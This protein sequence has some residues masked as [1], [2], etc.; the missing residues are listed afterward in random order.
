MMKTS[1]F[2]VLLALLPACA[3]AQAD[4]ESVHARNACRLAVQIVETGHPAPH[5]QW[6]FDYVVNCGRAGGDALANAIHRTRRVTDTVELAAVTRSLRTFRDG[7][8]FN[9]ALD[10]AGDRSATVQARVIA[11]RTLLVMMSPGRSLSYGQM[12]S[13]EENG[14]CLGRP[15]GFH[16]EVKEG[17][18][19]PPR[20]AELLRVAASRVIEDASVP[21]EL[22]QAARC[23]AR[24]AHS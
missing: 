8:V 16:D 11:F 21:A 12:T 6:A 13:L 15:R 19:L 24:Y 4:P 5:S 23:A 17:A 22:R 1:Y 14:T 2:A 9:A 7:A 20:H 3:L 18:P 10:V